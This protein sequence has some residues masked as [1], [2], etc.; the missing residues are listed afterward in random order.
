MAY[1]KRKKECVCVRERVW[2]KEKDTEK[3]L[4]RDIAKERGR[5]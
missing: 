2:D 3:Q 1:V 4:T 5:E